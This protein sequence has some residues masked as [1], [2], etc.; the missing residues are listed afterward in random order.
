MGTENGAKR[1]SQRLA[2]PLDDA[3]DIF[4]SLPERE[5]FEPSSS[6]SAWSAEVRCELGRKNR[7]GGWNF[8]F[9]HGSRVLCGRMQERGEKKQG[10]RQD[11]HILI[12]CDVKGKYAV[13]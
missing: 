7:A 4:T 9:G 10:R 6:M 1:P 13:L 3:P 11:A 2:V 12:R 8:R 5:M